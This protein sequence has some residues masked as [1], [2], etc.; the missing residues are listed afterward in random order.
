MRKFISLL[1]ALV[2]VLSLVGCVQPYKEQPL[3]NL[4]PVQKMIEDIA[5][6]NLEEAWNPVYN[7]KVDPELKETLEQYAEM[8]A[9][10]EVKRCDCYDFE[11]TGDPTVSGEVYTEIL[12]FKI[13]LLED[14]SGEPDYYAKAV[15][16]NDDDGTGVISLE[17]YEEDPVK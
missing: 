10:R 3:R 8:F 5:T 2:C 1:L 14:Y 9:G 7:R 16:I 15:G 6:G 17:I 11:R 13:Y 12:Y 4:M